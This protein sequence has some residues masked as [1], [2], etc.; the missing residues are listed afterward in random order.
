MLLLACACE[1]QACLTFSSFK[2]TLP[3]VGG[4]RCCGQ[5]EV[6]CH[7]DPL[8]QLWD[9]TAELTGLS[10][11]RPYLVFGFL[12]SLFFSPHMALYDICPS[13]FSQINTTRWARNGLRGED[14]VHVSLS[15]VQRIRKMGTSGLQSRMVKTKRDF[16]LWTIITVKLTKHLYYLKHIIHLN[17][18]PLSDK[19]YRDAP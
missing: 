3:G 4:W 15:E 1:F 17:L 10:N 14:C 13:A 9:A 19:N 6:I 18:S 2:P 7:S 11:F 12:P 16:K 5:T 8:S